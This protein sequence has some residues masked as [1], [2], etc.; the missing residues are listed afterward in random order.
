MEKA[1]VCADCNK[2]LVE[3]Y[4]CERCNA[5]FCEKHKVTHME[6]LECDECLRDVCMELIMQKQIQGQL[7]SLCY[8]C[9]FNIEIRSAYDTLQKKGK[10]HSRQ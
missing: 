9:Y 6:F 4:F 5:I 8:K 10:L 2:T 1:E 3:Y 7:V